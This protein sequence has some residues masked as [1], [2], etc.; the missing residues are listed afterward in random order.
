MSNT[1][2]EER[3]RQL[4]L[5]GQ[6]AAHEGPVDLMNMYL[7][8]HGFRRDLEAFSS[9]VPCTPVDDR[10]AWQALARRW[11]MF[12]EVLHHHHSAEDDWLWPVLTERADPA[13]RDTLEAM[14]A[15][16][17]EIDPALEACSA[18]F[19]RLARRADLD[20]RSA[21]TVRLSALRESLG[22]HLAHEE[23]DAIRLVQ[24]LMT[25]EDW[26]QFE[27]R[28]EEKIRFSQVLRLVPWAMH[29]VPPAAREEVFV[30][31]GAAHRV[32]WRLSRGRFERLQGRAFRHQPA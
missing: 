11:A 1:V 19:A 26:A 21:L 15:E 32:L 23:R 4:R 29:E 6:A 25:A 12:T 3:V 10:T 7:A 2:T 20:A 22:R 13:G 17:E 31:T 9:T 16:H 24:E 8:H 14:E 28:I 30:R 27:K 5:P 18:G